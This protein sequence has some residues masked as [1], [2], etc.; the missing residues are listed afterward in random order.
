LQAH[1]HLERLRARLTKYRK[2]KEQVDRK[3]M[4]TLQQAMKAQRGRRGIA[5]LFL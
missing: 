1:K 5:L 3:V 2:I 4:F